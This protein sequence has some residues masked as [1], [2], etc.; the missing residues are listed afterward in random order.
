[1]QGCLSERSDSMSR[2]RDPSNRLPLA[3]LVL[4]AAGTLLAAADARGDEV[5][6]KSGKVRKG[7]VVSEDARFVVIE[8]RFGPI[9]IAASE[10]VEVRRDAPRGEDTQKEPPK[11]DQPA[12]APVPAGDGT[13]ERPTDS[14]EEVATPPAG[15]AGDA[16]ASA[17]PGGDATA[18]AEAVSA[19]PG[20]GPPS[21]RLRRLRASRVVRRTTAAEEP[22]AAPAPKDEP[23]TTIG[24]RALGTVPKGTEVIVFQPPRPFEAAPGTIEI[25]K[26]TLARMEM[27]GSAS[28][29][30]TTSG[31]DGEQRI[32]IR[33]ADVKRHVEV[34]SPDARMRLFE[35]INPGDWVRLTTTSGETVQGRLVEAADGAVQLTTVAADQSTARSTIAVETLVS[36]DGMLRDSAA[37]LALADVAAGE[38]L[39]VTFWP[40]GEQIMGRHVESP[41]NVLSLDVDDDGVGDRTLLRDGPLAE[42]R[43]VPARLRELA[44]HL[45]PG[46]VVE[47]TYRDDTPDAG[48]RQTTLGA[49]EALTAFALA[50]RQGDGSEAAVVPFDAVAELL[51][52]ENDPEAEIAR[53]NSRVPREVA[54]A[55]LPVL[56]G[57]SEKEAAGLQLPEGVSTVSDGLTVS[58][59]FVAAP[60]AGELFGLRVGEPD[61]QSTRRS[62]LRF[63]TKVVPRVAGGSTPQPRQQIS[64]SIEGLRVVLLS[65]D[66]GVV[67]GIEISQA[68]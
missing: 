65:D 30:M 11:T 47:V 13:A 5:V 36:V 27:A 8:S 66:M 33:L 44:T 64:D 46:H 1:M 38:L 45:R 68:E 60:F 2:P 56:P 26:R 55:E 57:M 63:D 20:S 3:V 41:A 17:E 10:V 61:S 58:H 42:V 54:L 21:D 49:V 52:V 62:S 43:R 24:G 14:P 7:R 29:W 51:L 37:E 25:G 67:T 59:V 50:V 39:A 35:G 15:E 48:V 31:A 4:A 32:V 18:A 6:L 53:W 28:A 40:G 16:D 12:P 23:E 9:R 34:T 22:Q 19:E